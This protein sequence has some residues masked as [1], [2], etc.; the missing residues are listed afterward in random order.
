MPSI[1]ELARQKSLEHPL[2]NATL[3][4][5]KPRIMHRTG[6]P[7][8]TWKGKR[9][10]DLSPQEL[11]DRR[12]YYREWYLLNIDRLREKKRKNSAKFRSIHKDEINEK[13]RTKY[14]MENPDSKYYHTENKGKTR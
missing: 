2:P 13:R 12:K 7:T 6:I 8:G 4:V 1:Y 10:K 11:E 5:D 14:H 9:V 3:A